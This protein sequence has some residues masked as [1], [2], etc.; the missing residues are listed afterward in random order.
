MSEKKDLERE[1]RVGG[2][3][4]TH[5]HEFTISIN[6][7]TVTTPAHEL[8]GVALKQLGGIPPD[9]ELFRVVG[10]NTV[11]VANDEIVHLHE[12]EEFRA[13]P[14]GTFGS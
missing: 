2:Q 4:P 9:Y 3:P 7:R 13:I 12:R 8:S 10:S 14:A 6:N 1:T 11:P 5:A